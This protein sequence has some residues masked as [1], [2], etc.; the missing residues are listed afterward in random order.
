MMSSDATYCVYY[1]KN[2]ILHQITK[3]FEKRILRLNVGC[4]KGCFVA[5][6]SK[7]VVVAG[8]VSS[9]N[10]LKFE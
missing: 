9:V 7:L 8:I 5:W 2:T 3:C 6:Q 10:A 1:T 4:W